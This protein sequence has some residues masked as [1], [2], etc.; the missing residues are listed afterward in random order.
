[1]A[2][3]KI[4]DLPTISTINANTANTVL[5]GVDIPTNITGQ[6]TLTTLANGLYSNNYLTVGD[7]SHN[8]PNAIAVFAGPSDNYIQTI[9]ENTDDDGTADFVAQSNVSTDISHFIDIGFT[10]NNYNNTLPV[11]SLGTSVGQLDG[12]LYVQGKENEKGGN[13][14]IGTVSSNTRINFIVGGINSEN[15]VAYMTTSGIYSPTINSL[16]AANV[17]ILR[18]EISSNAVSSNAVINSRISSN[19]ATANIFTQAAFNKANNALAN[20]SGIFAGNLNIIGDLSLLNGSLLTTGDMLVNGTLTLAN[21][22]FSSIESAMTIKATANVQLPANDGYM[23]HISGKNGIPARVVTDSFG[24]NSYALFAGRSARGTVDSPSSTQNNDV[25]LRV[26]SG[27]WGTTGFSPLGSGRIDFVA[28]ENHTDSARGSAIKF[29]NVSNG[30]NTITNIATFNGDSAI[31]SG[32]V[33]PQKGFIY[34]PNVQSTLTSYTL[35]FNNDNLVKFDINQ[36]ISITLTNFTYGKVVEL[37]MTNSSG[38]NRTITHGCLANNSTTK[39]TTF[40]IQALS[41][42]YLKYFS[43]N[44]DQANTFV[45]IVA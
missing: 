1:M 24:T 33:N 7:F 8:F 12:Y 35:D 31:F 39:T 4:T 14:V 13:L 28:T 22:N 9:I 43:I 27:G 38:A 37:W 32:V 15:V 20:T 17:G 45:S 5:V 30:T 21:S 3:V 18:S 10:G 26:S 25:L 29:Y 2:T 16:V 41:C 36:N 34:T 42:A 19:I 40:V 6:I 11:N 44:G 23:I